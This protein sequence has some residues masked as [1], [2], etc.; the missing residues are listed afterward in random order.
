LVTICVDSPI[1]LIEILIHGFSYFYNNI[2]FSSRLL[3]LFAVEDICFCYFI[4]SF[5]D[6]NLLNRVLDDFYIRDF[7]IN[8][9]FDF[10]GYFLGKGRYFF[11]VGAADG[12]DSFFDRSFDLAD[13]EIDNRSISF[14]DFVDCHTLLL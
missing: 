13:V 14:P 2:G 6:E 11:E 4:V 9:F 1:T 7:F 12:F 3:S 10:F 8:F 5:F